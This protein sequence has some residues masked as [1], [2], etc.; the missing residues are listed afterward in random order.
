MQD[1]SCVVVPIRDHAFFEQTVFQC[2][3]SNAFLQRASLTA[4]VF[5]L[6]R[7]GSTRRVASKLALA[8]F[9]KLLRPGV[10]QAL[11]DAFTAT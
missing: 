3:I 4:Q 7:C 8:R 2:Q 9:H 10:I 11:G 5:Y 1:I 6:I